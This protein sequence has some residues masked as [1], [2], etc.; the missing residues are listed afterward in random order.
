MSQW[1]A[2][3]CWPTRRRRRRWLSLTS[4]CPMVGLVRLAVKVMARNGV[5]ILLTILNI[6]LCSLL[7]VTIESL[8]IKNL[9]KMIM[10]VKVPFF[11]EPFQSFCFDK[12]HFKVSSLLGF[13]STSDVGLLDL[14]SLMKL[15]VHFQSLLL[16]F[17]I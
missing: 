6:V 16:W 11:M 3:T 8:Q 5:N 12:L 7:T 4:W 15:N 17:C 2:W 13:T 9:A 14:Y 10:I 1:L